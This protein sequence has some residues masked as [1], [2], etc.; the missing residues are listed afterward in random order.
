LTTGGPISPPRSADDEKRARIL[1]AAERVCARKGVVAARME[2]IAAEAQVSKGTL[3]RFFDAKEELLVA[4]VIESYAAGHRVVDA[5]F[6][7]H[8]D[9]GDVL[10]LLLEGLPR[11]LELQ[12]P[13]APLHYAVWEV[14]AHEPRLR[15]KLYDYLRGFFRARAAGMREAIRAGQQAGRVRRNVDADAFAD[16]ILAML[17][18]FIFRATFDPEAASPAR[19]AAAYRVLVRETLF[20]AP[21]G[22]PD[23]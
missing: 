8:Q 13:R 18:G 16:A 7:P 2:E 17:S 12:A 3:Y 20:R 15:A 21:Q 10:E 14:A 19:L 11:V 22:D 1:E 23:V 5:E 9:P 6:P 4:M